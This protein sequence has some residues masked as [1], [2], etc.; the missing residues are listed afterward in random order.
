M[1]SVA[2]FWPQTLPLRGK[3][4]GDDPD[5][6]QWVI[7]CT[8]RHRQVSSL[9]LLLSVRILTPDWCTE[10]D[11]P[12][13]VEG[14]L[15]ENMAGIVFN[16]NADALKQTLCALGVEYW[17]SCFGEIRLWLFGLTLFFLWRSSF[18]SCR[19]CATKTLKT[20]RTGC[21]GYFYESQKCGQLY[22]SWNSFCDC[23]NLYQPITFSKA[24]FIAS[25][26][27]TLSDWPESPSSWLISW[28]D[29][30]RYFLLH[31]HFCL[32]QHQER[33]PVKNSALGAFSFT[34]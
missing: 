25:S 23:C 16:M 26:K 9:I 29:F 32:Q 14:A 30:V 20:S 19:N 1:V 34:C 10:Y 18:F 22:L 13:N 11:T 3:W 27:V 6:T 17:V 21:A 12:I 31:F 28:S 2:I 5:K 8:A 7:Q 33:S 4:F 24:D 15:Y